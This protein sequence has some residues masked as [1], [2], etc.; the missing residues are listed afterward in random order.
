M[1]DLQ[2]AY[3]A[4]R[5]GWCDLATNAPGQQAMDMA[6]RK[7]AE[8]GRFRLFAALVLDA[9]TDERAWGSARRESGGLAR[10]STA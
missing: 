1:P 5:D 8:M 9:K 6:Q 7:R 2:A 4:W 10:S 3:L